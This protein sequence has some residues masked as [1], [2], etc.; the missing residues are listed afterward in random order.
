[1]RL[2]QLTEVIVKHAGARK[3]GGAFLLPAEAE[4]S[5]YV[6]LE[7]ETLTI[8]KVARI[9]PV[10]ALVAVDT[11]RGERFIVAAEDVRGVKVDRS[12]N[13]R[14]ERSAGFGK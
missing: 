11:S 13:A 4:A 9:E 2:D 12:E 6:A 7:G 14:R 1:M 10:D 5:L 8:Q 3:D